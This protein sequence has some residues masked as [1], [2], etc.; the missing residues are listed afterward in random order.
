MRARVLLPLLLVGWLAGVTAVLAQPQIP[1]TFFGTASVD[2]AAPPG[3]TDIRAFVDALDCTQLG[4]GPRYAIED[5]LGTYVVNVMHE[6]Q[7][8]GC[9]RDGKTVTFTI[10]GRTA[11]QTAVW[12]PGPQEVNLNVG[13]GTPIPLPS[14]TPT[15]TARPG[16]TQTN[17]TPSDDPG[18]GTPPRPTGTPP[19]DDITLTPQPR[20]S[21]TAAVRETP[22]AP[23][24]VGGSDGEGG[25]AWPIFVVVG[26]IVALAGGGAGLVLSRRLHRPGTK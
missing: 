16:A 14:R 8:V 17:G 4:P 20:G 26:G 23:S 7:K 3:D 18:S 13:S 10:A 24:S 1:S 6:S 19:T 22:G 21:T 12:K 11:D 9:G 2:G 25:S 15:P 5:G